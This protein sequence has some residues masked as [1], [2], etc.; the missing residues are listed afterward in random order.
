MPQD[1]LLSRAFLLLLSW[2]H[3]SNGRRV[4]SWISIVVGSDATHGYSMLIGR[5]VAPGV[6]VEVIQEGLIG[7]S[8]LRRLVYQPWV[9]AND[10][11][12][13]AVAESR[14]ISILDVV[15]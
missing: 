9:G 12:A 4:R 10:I 13:A 8:L 3:S 14:P 1:S 7:P 11:A 6:K 5:T 2:F 15:A